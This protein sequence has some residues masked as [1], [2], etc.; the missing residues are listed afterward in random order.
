[1]LFFTTVK[2]SQYAWNSAPIDNTDIGRSVAA[3]GREFRFP[4]DVELLPT[5]QLNNDTNSALFDYLPHVSCNTEFA[6]S[7]LQILVEERHKYHQERANLSRDSFKFKLGDVVK[8]HVTV[9]SNAKAGVVGKLSYQ[10][11]GPFIIIDVLD[12]DS[13]LVRDYNNPN[14]TS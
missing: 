9:K 8:A 5:P 2:T 14:G 6:R 13:Y 1:M 12:H 4:L 11:K 3:L 7:V 10:A